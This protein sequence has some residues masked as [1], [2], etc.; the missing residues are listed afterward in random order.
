MR[1]YSIERFERGCWRLYGTAD[2]LP[3]ACARYKSATKDQPD[4][5]FRLLNR[6]NEIIISNYVGN[7]NEKENTM[8]PCS[9]RNNER[10]AMCG[11]PLPTPPSEGTW[12]EVTEWNTLRKGD[13]VRLTHEN[14]NEAAFTIDR[15]RTHSLITEHNSYEKQ[16]GWRVQ[17]WRDPVFIPSAPNTAWQDKNG[18]VYLVNP[19]GD[20]RNSSRFLSQHEARGLAPWTQLLPAKQVAE[21]VLDSVEYLTNVGCTRD[22]ALSQIRNRIEKGVDL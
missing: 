2:K 5:F 8:K 17:V 20:L 9:C 15:V 19:H 16:H 11:A 13:K 7:P 18:D 4:R 21:K 3:Q 1:E 6:R 22:E 12:V 14:G 10:C